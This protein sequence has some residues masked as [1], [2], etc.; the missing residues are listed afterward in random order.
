MKSKLEIEE[1]GEDYYLESDNPIFTNVREQD[2]L[3]LIGRIFHYIPE[4][5]APWLP[6]KEKK[7]VHSY[8]HFKQIIGE[9]PYQSCYGYARF[10]EG[11]IKIDGD[12]HRF[13]V[14]KTISGTKLFYFPRLQCLY[15]AK[16][17]Y[18]S[19]RSFL[20]EYFQNFQRAPF[21][22]ITEASLLQADV[23]WVKRYCEDDQ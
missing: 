14:Y 1:L 19:L 6:H 13:F 21:T 7:K 12:E 9:K 23:E 22:P 17:E 15:T 4:Y 11:K 10:G 2:F 8:E 3:F 18:S 5:Q 16:F 20:A